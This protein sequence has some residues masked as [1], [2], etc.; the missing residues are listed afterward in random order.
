MT[1]N[2]IISM[3]SFNTSTLSVY[4]L[5]IC[6][7][8]CEILLGDT[9]H[10][11]QEGHLNLMGKGAMQMTSRTNWKSFDISLQNIIVGKWRWGLWGGTIDIS[12]V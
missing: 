4:I 2:V 3:I 1:V 12:P 9:G 5:H 8:R 6:L 10:Y 11:L 7:R